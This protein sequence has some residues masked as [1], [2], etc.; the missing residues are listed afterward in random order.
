MSNW[1]WGVLPIGGI[2]VGWGMSVFERRFPRQLPP[3]TVPKPEPRVIFTD[4]PHCASHGGVLDM[5]EPPVSV[6]TTIE[7]YGKEVPVTM[8]ICQACAGSQVIPR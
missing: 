5:E 1:I 8:F 3:P 4:R 2:L 7:L 6:H